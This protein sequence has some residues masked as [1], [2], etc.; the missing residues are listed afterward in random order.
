MK[1][2][3]TVRRLIKKQADYT[4]GGYENAVDDGHLEK[5][6]TKEI[7]AE[8]IYEEVINLRNFKE[9]QTDIRFLGTE[10][11]KDMIN[12]EIDNQF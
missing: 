2:E 6:P 11:I 10:K 8:E 9:F 5:M 7:M 12:E 4:V 1:R 3:K